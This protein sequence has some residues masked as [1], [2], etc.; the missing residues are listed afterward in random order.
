M[1]VQKAGE[2]YVKA[3]RMYKMLMTD[4]QEMKLYE[5]FGESAPQGGFQLLDLIITELKSHMMKSL[6]KVI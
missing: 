1:E 6:F 5:T 3:K 2:D 4:F